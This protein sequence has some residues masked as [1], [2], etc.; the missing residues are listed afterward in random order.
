[1]H[2][3]P[4][5]FAEFRAQ[6]SVFRPG[7]LNV[8]SRSAATKQVI[9]VVDMT[10]DPAYSHGEPATVAFV[11]LSGVRTL[12]TVPMLKE[13][14]FIG[15]ISVFRQDVRRFTDKQIALL[16]NFADQAVIAIENA[17]L[18]NE[19]RQRTDDLSESLQQ[20]TA[21]SEVLTVISSSPGDLEPVFH[22]LLENATRL[23]QA[24]FAGLFLSTTEG[25]RNVAMHG[26]TSPIFDLL[27]RVPAV[28]FSEH[29]HLP[30]V[31]AAQTKQVVH[32]TDVFADPSY[33]ERDPNMVRLV[34]STGARTLLIMPM[35][36][37][38][39]LIGVIAIYRQEVRPFTDKQIDLLQNFAA[40]AV[41]A[42][43][44]AR[45][46]TELRESLERQTA[47]SEVLGVISR[48]KFDLQPILQSV[49]ETAERLCRADQ[50]VI[51]RLQDGAYRF[52][53]GHSHTPEYLELEQKSII[54]PG[55]GTLIG[56]AVLTRQVARIDDAW[57][58]PLYEK[59]GDA[60]IGGARSMIGVPLMR[61]GEPIGAIGLARSRVDP[62][63]ER[64][65]ELVV[66][67]ADQAVIAI[68]NAR[69]FEAEQQRTRELTESLEQQTATSEVLEVISRS[70]F[71]LQTVLDTLVESAERLC[72]AHFA[73]I[74]RKEG[75]GYRLAANHGFSAEYKAWMQ[76]HTIAP[77]SK[78]LVG[79][80]AVARR[81][82][83]IPD[84]TADPDYQWAES[85]S[86]GGFRTMLGV[87]LMREGEPIGVIAIC[88]K[89]VSPFT[90][91]QIEL[92][93][94]FADQAVIAI[95][96]ARLLSELRESLEQQTATAN[97]L[98]VI[99]R[100]AF[101]LRAVFETV[102][103]SSVRL[104]GADRAFIFRFDGELLRM[105]ASFNAA[106]DFVEWVAQHPI[107]PGRHSGSARAALE[108]R[109]IHIPDV[110]ADP[111][112]VY[113]AKDVE[114]IRTIL[115]VPILKGDELLG[116]MMIYHLE[117][118]PFTDKQI[119]L[120]ETFADQ[121]AI[122]IENV[123]LFEAEQQ[124]TRELTESLEQQTATA[125]V[126]SVISTSP[127]D[128]APVFD[129][130]LKSAT[131]LCEA[132]F[133]TLFLRDGG[134]LRLVAR[135][136][137]AEGRAFFEL[138]SQLVLAD[139]DGHPLV[140]VLETKSVFHLA[141]LRADPSYA[142]GNPRVVA[143]VEKVGS[144][145]A[146]CVPMMKD[147]ECIGVIVTSRPEVR[148]FTAKQ[149][150]LVKNF[151]AQAVIAIENARLL[152]ELRE[153]LEQQTATAKVLQVI[154]GSA[155]D[156]ETVL[157]TLL[158]SAVQLCQADAAAIWRPDGE[159]LKLAAMCGGSEEQ[160]EFFR[161]NPVRR[162]DTGKISGRVMQQR[163]T[164]H[165]ADVQAE[166]GFTG[167]DYYAGNLR[168]SLGVPLLRDGEVIGVF[169]LVRRTVR[170]FSEKQ[171]EL[172]ETFAD[173]AVI[174]IENARLLN[175][176]RESLEQQTAT[177]EVLGV[178][179][180][181]PGEL[182]PVFQ[183]MLDNAVRICGAK[184][185]NIYRYDNETLRL[186]A[187]HSKTPPALAEARRLTPHH[188]IKRNTLISEM[189]DTKAAVQV[190]DAS[191]LPQYFDRTDPGAVAAVD[192]GGARSVLAVPMLKDDELIGS[193]TLY[194]DEVR[195]FTG[196]QVAL[197]TG[198]A[199]QA[200][201]AI[202][203]ARLLSELRESLEQQTATSEVLSVISSSPGDLEPVF[204]SMLANAVRISGARFGIIHAWNGETLRL[205]ATHNLPPEL[206]SARRG[207]PEFRPGPKTAVHRVAV[208]K[209]AVHLTD[210]REDAG[211]IEERAPQVVAAVEI[212]GVRTMLAVPML[213][214][215][216]VV[217]IFTLYRQE[218]RPFPEKQIELVKN[219]AAQAVIAIENARLLSELRLSLERQTA[220]ADILRI[221][222]QSPTDA[223]PAFEGIA[224]TAVR[225][226]GS[227]QVSVMLRD[228][229]FFSVV[230]D[231][232][233]DGPIADA[234]MAKNMPIDASANFPSRAII[235]RKMLHLP[236]WSLIDPP[237]FELKM[238][239]RFGIRSALYLPLLRGRECIGLITLVGKRPNIFGP[240]EIAQAESFR[241]Q[242]LIAI[243]NTRLFNELRSRTA[244][245]GR[246]VEELR[247]LGE[248]S[249]A[250]NSTLDLEMV[251]N[252]IVTKAA[253][254]SGTEAGAIYVFDDNQREFHLRATVGME[255]GLITALSD[256]HIRLDDQNI[257]LVLTNR[258][259]VQVAD[260]AEAARSTVDDIVLRAGYRARLAAPLFS[261]DDIV[262]LLVVRRRT[263]GAF[264]PNTVD[265]MKTFAAQSA[266]A[267]QNA[268][269]FQEIDDKGRELELASRH[270]SQF[271]AN[272]SHEL[273]TPLNAI[274][275]YTEL[276]LD[277]IYG[278]AP[279][280][281][282]AVLERVQT[283]GKHLLG[284]INDVLDLSK[285]EAGQLTLSLNDYSL[286][287]LVQGVYVAVEPLASRK[288]LALTT[289]VEKGLP[290]GHG[291]ERRLAQVLLNLVGNAIKFTDKGEV[292]I[293]ASAANGAFN[294]AVRDSGPG[295]AAADQQKIFEEF[296]QVDD[297]STRQKGGTGLGL[298]ISKR[299][300][301][302]HGGRIQV[303]SELGKG[304][305]FTIRLPVKAGS[306][307]Q[308][309]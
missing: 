99:S 287:E 108:R 187:A 198:F 177:S 43:E 298:A 218:I 20:Q 113:G 224:V 49:V 38:T 39:E 281:M 148:P 110:R 291:D 173:Q 301:E 263:P 194:R 24:Q 68:E 246:S 273:R 8:L 223:R 23:C 260:L 286:A 302:L 153:S 66:T 265:L 69:L 118:R 36:K 308:M 13:S 160:Q 264:P 206:E 178:I 129:A 236:D 245:L 158:E 219:F 214:D 305:T 179:S 289:K 202:E 104:C 42:I 106:P 304:S 159:M 101:D 146:L 71:D 102:A 280:K 211:Y 125:E 151:A 238:Q 53:A 243:E 171:I 1:L 149:T 115:G 136:V 285:I 34:E 257:T 154:S 67:F 175:E 59:Q 112:Y 61:Q 282:R 169:V 72:E 94:T 225:L 196:K 55:H 212:G 96:N 256:A 41:I 57:S 284:L 63:T 290:A 114:A 62:F 183:T 306:E 163:R 14:E 6:E 275:G 86:R 47:T 74:F 37:E 156:L 242:A 157:D 31:R 105:A 44:N 21:T 138:G 93:T 142:A 64:E 272:M 29:P 77:G 292:A 239:K 45:L 229:D 191:A 267:I 147:D 228:G 9:H 152:S 46:L 250:V 300:V 111:E 90:N 252:T 28:L 182:D 288:N 126:L 259:P 166:P 17:R 168:T 12:L 269:L 213:K 88:R 237:E 60:K 56:R 235:D 18:L 30:I 258:E 215:G 54:L 145:T 296:Q 133:G 262:G 227:H 124:R 217:G 216:E 274:L 247:A 294:L 119:A 81:T 232:T 180:R 137:P 192:L 79:R 32:I 189:I 76:T 172:V 220:T 164:V 130:M 91:K 203:N 170:P 226:L 277:N 7:P 22:A 271:L 162:D 303:D 293:E 278:E 70:A 97:V 73:F 255:Q 109:T 10:E 19:L 27:K 84:A 83:H 248:T 123:R 120:V 58:D 132:N 240:A 210:L 176:L 207:A 204:Q 78:T 199:A 283:N 87:P 184:F 51:F 140:R 174:A 266:L 208:T 251:L 167:G 131:R 244:E 230:A 195:P 185:G 222:S 309:A 75:Q 5:N 117:V 268:R 161:R 299:I 26:G 52:A 50:T 139:N 3:P 85:I 135:H 143:F 144:R 89:I 122:A 80:T 141:D 16:K 188:N 15:A 4:A 186:A 2:N 25:L 307:G 35:L 253:Q 276:I 40:Q 261:G 82:V 127:G 270:K 150:D 197:V 193:F 33:S 95:E 221:I 65:I 116:V 48:S 181:S 241:D 234:L 121:A 233:A 98:E 279:E 11:D 128:L 103:E 254:L 100:S 209:R 295:I 155:F 200:V 205:L 134:A 165:I 107:R 201:I 190:P 249:Q 231:A 297:T 92:M